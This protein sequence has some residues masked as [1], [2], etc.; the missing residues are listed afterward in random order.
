MTQ[1]T[2]NLGYTANSG[3]SS[4]NVFITV[5]EPRAPTSN[6]VNYPVQKRWFN[7]ELATEYILTSFTTTASN[8]TAN[9]VQIVGGLDV[10]T[11]FDGDTGEAV[12]AL[13]T[14]VFTGST[15][16]LTF[17]GASNI[18]TLGGDLN[19]AHGGTGSTTFNANG[20]VI[21]GTT[22]TSALTSLALTDGQIVIGS[23]TGAPA[24]A[25]ITAGTNVSIVNDHNSITISADTTSQTVHYTNVNSSPYTV[26]ST[27]FYLSVDCSAGAIT[28]N[29]PNAPDPNRIWVIKDR[30]GSAVTHNITITTPGGTVTFDGA[31][32]YV[33]K[34]NY[35][36]V[37]LMA[38]AAPTYEVY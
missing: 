31:A 36:A 24:A 3:A 32:T 13:N 9:W 27:D 14:I 15:T 26:L 8:T 33:M 11:K 17:T 2:S 21:S 30:T 10:A 37:Q 34:T 7:T 35:Q 23:T 16:G 12:P 38:N 19:V 28:L 4:N 1:P 20:A 22:T 18:M 25:T 29:F 6:D 5:F